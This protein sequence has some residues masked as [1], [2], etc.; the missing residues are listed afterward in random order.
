MRPP[1]AAPAITLVAILLLGAGASAA[2]ADTRLTAASEPVPAQYQG[3]YDTVSSNLDGYAAAL[4]ATKRV[5]DAKAPVQGAELLSANGNRFAA[6]LAPGTMTVV[7]QELAALRKA[8]VRGVT[9][10][11][12]LPLVLPT[13]TPEAEQY[14]AFYA[15]V[16]KKARAAGMAVS[17]ELGAPFCGTV[18]ATCSYQWPASI[19][20]FAAITATQAQTVIDRV[21]PDYLTVLAEPTTEASLTKITDFTT[22]EGSA[23]YVHGVLA[24]ITHRRATKI[25]A[26]A[27]SWLPLTYAQ[28]L[29]HERIDY[30]D[31]HIYP[32]STKIGQ[33]LADTAALARRHH[34]PLVIDEVWLYKTGESN[35]DNTVAQSEE[36]F[37][38]DRFGFFA[39]LDARFL[40]VTREWA[41]RAGV[42]YESA[43]WSGQLLATLPWT[44]ELDALGYQQLSAAANRAVVAA[45]ASGAT[46]PAGEAWA[47]KG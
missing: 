24:G 8:G 47:G 30:L 16:A 10:G 36:K 14:T 45:M 44:P 17:V 2:V 38:L 6:L 9:L 46:T 41:R 11:I 12:K 40:T 42:A 25:G 35:A 19:D 13:Y 27:G 20:E 31:S 29:V 21:R 33:T 22:P 7:D 39:P 5:G 3:L 18:F 32:A 1:R 23:R 4:A 43:F 37:R 15:T 26:G 34:L 28:L